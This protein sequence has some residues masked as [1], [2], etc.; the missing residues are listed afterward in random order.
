ML[1]NYFSKRQDAAEKKSSVIPATIAPDGSEANLRRSVDECLRVLDGKKSID[2][3]EC[4]RLDPSFPV[5][6]T[7][8]HLAAFVNEEKIKSIKL[9]EFDAQ[10]ICRA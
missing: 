9:S 8:C 6:E 2:I 1:H 3:F 7:V 5:D 10:P 4:A